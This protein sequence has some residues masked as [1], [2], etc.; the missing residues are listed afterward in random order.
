L[1]NDDETKAIYFHTAVVYARK[2]VMGNK[3]ISAWGVHRG[4]M[5]KLDTGYLIIEEKWFPKK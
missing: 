5:A 4:Q 2:I 1:S 3:L